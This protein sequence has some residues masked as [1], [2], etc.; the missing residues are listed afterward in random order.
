MPAFVAKN[1]GRKINTIKPPFSVKV[2]V[3]ICPWTLITCSY[4]ATYFLELRSRKIVNP[5]S[6]QIKC[7]WTN[8]RANFR[9]KWTIIYNNTFNSF[10]DSNYV[11]V[12]SID[13][14]TNA[15]AIKD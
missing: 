8:I 1:I 3:D 2:H 5:F 14:H 6:E 10:L 11:P 9:T 7:L 15:N 4:K 12:I 13:D